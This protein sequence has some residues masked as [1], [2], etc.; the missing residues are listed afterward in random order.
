MEVGACQLDGD[1]R[2]SIDFVS[3]YALDEAVGGSAVVGRYYY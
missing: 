2:L 1:L 3:Y